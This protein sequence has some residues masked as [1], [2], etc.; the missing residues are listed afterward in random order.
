MKAK[1]RKKHTESHRRFCLDCGAEKGIYAPGSR[2]IIGKATHF[3]CRHCRRICDPGH[4]CVS[5]DTSLTGIVASL[6]EKPYST[7]PR[8][9]QLFLT[10]YTLQSLEVDFAGF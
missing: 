1:R 6:S 2:I 10:L 3:L 8:E 5:V 4:Q 9:D 7:L